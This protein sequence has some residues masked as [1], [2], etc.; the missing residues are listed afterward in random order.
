MSR[1]AVLIQRARIAQKLSSF[2]ALAKRMGVTAA[3][4]SQWRSGASKLS[5]ERVEELALM[6]G[7]DPGIWS[8]AM[9]AEECNIRSIKTSVE[10]IVDS[11]KKPGMWS[12]VALLG[13]GMLMPATSHANPIEINN[14]HAS[15]AHSLYI[16][17][18]FV[19]WRG[20]FDSANKWRA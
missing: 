3:T 7:D 10:K 12:V 17:L 11:V 4:M 14:L 13:L 6:A 16:M 5:H 20:E 9:W 8:M 18:S 2:G 15:N 1:Q 19:Y